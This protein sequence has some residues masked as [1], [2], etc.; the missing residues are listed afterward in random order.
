MLVLIIKVVVTNDRQTKVFYL[1]SI[2]AL[3]IPFVATVATFIENPANYDSYTT[4]I[5]RI[6]ALFFVV[7]TVSSFL[8]SI[9]VYLLDQ[10]ILDQEV[11]KKIIALRGFSSTIAILMAYFIYSKSKS[12]SFSYNEENHRQGKLFSDFFS[13]VIGGKIPEEELLLAKQKLTHAIENK[14]TN[15]VFSIHVRQ[16]PVEHLRTFLNLITNQKVF[17]VAPRF[18]AQTTLVNEKLAKELQIF[19]QDQ[20][21]IE[22]LVKIKPKENDNNSNIV[23][24]FIA[25]NTVPALVRRSYSLHIT[26]LTTI[27][28]VFLT[29][30]MIL[31][32]YPLIYENFRDINRIVIKL[33]FGNFW[34]T[35][36]YSYYLVGNFSLAIFTSAILEMIWNY[37]KKEGKEFFLEKD[38]VRCI[39]KKN[40]RE[41]YC[42]YEHIK[43]Y[44]F[45]MIIDKEKS[46]HILLLHIQEPESFSREA[47]IEIKEK[48]I[49]K[50]QQVFREQEIKQSQIKYMKLQAL[51][52]LQNI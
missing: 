24:R 11:E 19:N 31:L 50:I 32:L 3:S 7:V 27:V 12:F 25:G 39:K 44:H 5:F 1:V 2:L 52:K 47:Y 38:K 35:R 23:Y 26:I 42:Q 49:E 8:I 33:G 40:F 34:K 46:H 22:H 17:F 6:L 29:L 28:L 45:G 15:V 48:D 10:K 16:V 9:I 37:G 41:H 21:L 51:K 18:E 20:E 43:S 36:P 14:I 4:R 13:I 30:G